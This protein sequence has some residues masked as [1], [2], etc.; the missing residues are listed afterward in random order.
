MIT[1]NGCVAI[2]NSIDPNASIIIKP[3]VQHDLETVKDLFTSY[4]KWL[5]LNLNF[6]DYEAEFSNLP[7]KYASD[8]GGCLLLA[9]SCSQEQSLK[10]IGC[11]A[12][13]KL[14]ITGDVLSSIRNHLKALSMEEP[15]PVNDATKCCELKRFFVTPS[16]RGMKVGNSLIMATLQEAKK[17]GY[18]YAFL[19]TL[20][21]R[22][23]GACTLYEKF[24]FKQTIP[25]YKTPIVDQ[26]IF[27]IKHL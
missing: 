12:M 22:M 2:N 11:L 6:Q 15:S 14:N 4:H 20:T 5:N 13:R 7:G 16:A 9:F 27:Y 8:Q 3:F 23:Q 19:D 24:G 25:Y 17:Q 18:E 1:D 21:D 10:P 26:T